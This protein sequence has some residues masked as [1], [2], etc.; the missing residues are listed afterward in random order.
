M[1]TRSMYRDLINDAKEELNDVKNQLNLP[2]TR[3]KMTTLIFREKYLQA[4]IA[5]YKSALSRYENASRKKV[6]RI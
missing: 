3:N 1:G 6:A 4:E 2:L 5:R